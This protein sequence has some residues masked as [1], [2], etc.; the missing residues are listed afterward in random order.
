MSSLSLSRY[1]NRFIMLT[2][3]T[4]TIPFILLRP[5]SPSPPNRSNDLETRHPR[6]PDCMPEKDVE[7]VSAAVEYM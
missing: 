7:S 4:I 5:I 2:D 1:F 3:V 6:A